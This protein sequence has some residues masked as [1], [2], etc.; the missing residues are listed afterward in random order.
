MV[1]RAKQRL[2]GYAKRFK[3]IMGHDSGKIEICGRV[4]DRLILKQLHSRPEQP[5][6]ASRVKEYELTDQA[7]WLDDMKEIL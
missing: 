3:Y 6:E 2:D 5:E 7:G 1:D 4:K